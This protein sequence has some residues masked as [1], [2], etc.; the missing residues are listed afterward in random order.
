VTPDPA[1][2]RDLARDLDAA[3][4]RLVRAHQDALYGTALRLTGCREDASDLTQETFV[5]AYRALQAYPADRIR[6]LKVRPWL[7]TIAANQCRNHLRR[8]S[9][10]PLTAHLDAHAE[11]AAPNP[12]PDE[13]GP[14]PVEAALVALPGPQRLAVLMRHVAGIPVS[15]IAAALGRP[16]GTVK[17]D[18]HRGLVALRAALG[19]QEEEAS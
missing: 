11:P 10:R 2:S 13:L 5:R 9:R 15:E 6:G 18:I 16:A 14:G 4:P 12:S 8:R 7:W 3:F 1:L 17:S 19:E